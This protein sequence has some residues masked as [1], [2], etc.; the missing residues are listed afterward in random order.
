MFLV[1][2]DNKGCRKSSAA[3]ID[4]TDNQVYCTECDNPKNLLVSFAVLS[5][6]KNLKIL[7]HH[8]N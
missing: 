4:L 8:F 2:C 5:A 6:K 7:Q 3:V 1:Q